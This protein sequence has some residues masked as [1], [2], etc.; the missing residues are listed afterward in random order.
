MSEEK[1]TITKKKTELNAVAEEINCLSYK[2]KF[3][4]PCLVHSDEEEVSF[5]FDIARLDFCDKKNFDRDEK[6]RFLANCSELYELCGEFEFALK[7]NNLMCDINLCPRVLV[8][9]KCINPDYREDFLHKYKSL[10]AC[11]LCPRF[12]YED[13]LN[14]GEDLFRKNSELS[15]V[16]ECKD[17]EELREYLLNSYMAYVD[18]QRE[19]KVLVNRKHKTA[20]KVCVPILIVLAV[21]L[22]VL[23]SFAYFKMIPFKIE[24]LDADEEYFSGNYIEVQ[25]ALADISVDELPFAQKYILSRSYVSSESMTQDQKENVLEGITMNTNEVVMDYWIYVGRLDFDDAIDQAQKI[26]DD[27]LLLYALIKQRSNLESDSSISG[28]AK[29]EQ[30]NEIDEKISTITDSVASAQE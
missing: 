7:P 10:V 22:G 3:L 27:E 1:F 24:L 20:I 14:G 5:E 26:G 25:E 30:L 12:T 19:N 2:N 17:V 18:N 15:A 21:A 13:Y 23:A 8:R 28:E 16:M 29:T 4:A 11:V 6:Y 9:D